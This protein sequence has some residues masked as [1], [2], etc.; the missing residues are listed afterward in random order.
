[1][2]WLGSGFSSFPLLRTRSLVSDLGAGAAGE[3]SLHVA[4]PPPPAWGGAGTLVSVLVGVA[5]SSSSH[6]APIPRRASPMSGDDLR[7]G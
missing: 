7:T 2:N 3:R 5:G 6:C 4:K 1:M